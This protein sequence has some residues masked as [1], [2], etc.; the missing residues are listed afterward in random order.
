[1]NRVRSVSSQIPRLF[2]CL[3]FEAAVKKHQAERHPGPFSLWMQ[4]IAI[5]FRQLGH[6]Q[7]LLEITGSLAT[8]EGK[9]RHLGVQSPRKRSALAYPSAAKRDFL[10][11]VI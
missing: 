8:C 1:M 7:T 3:E 10:N 4:F 11:L 5:L 9:F 2:P 6:A